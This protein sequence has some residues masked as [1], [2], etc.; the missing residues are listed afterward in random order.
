MAVWLQFSLVCDGFVLF[1]ISSNFLVL[2]I[3]CISQSIMSKQTGTNMTT[4]CF[5][6]SLSNK[7]CYFDCLLI[8]YLVR[9][10]CVWDYYL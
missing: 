1:V 3:A 5:L 6:T 9:S 7:T 8:Y 2:L 10:L 4:I